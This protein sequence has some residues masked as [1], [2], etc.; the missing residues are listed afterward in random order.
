ARPRLHDERKVAVAALL[1]MDAEQIA[2]L[3]RLRAGHAEAV[4]QQVSEAGR[5]RS[6][7]HYD[8]HPDGDHA[9]AMADDPVGPANQSGL[10]FDPTAPASGRLTTRSGPWP[11]GLEPLARA[12][13]HVRWL[14]LLSLGM[15]G[16]AQAVGSASFQIGR[17]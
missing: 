8:N 9:L 17:M 1:E 12:G 7:E 10:R 3:L 13:H 11:F 16:V 14:P 6:T 15:E 2:S 4:R 5:R